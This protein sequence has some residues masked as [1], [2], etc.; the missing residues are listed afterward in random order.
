MI[1][2]KK[3]KSDCDEERCV[4]VGIVCVGSEKKEQALSRVDVESE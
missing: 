4:V 2:M 3:N 1:S